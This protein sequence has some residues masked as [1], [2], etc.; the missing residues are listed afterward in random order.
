MTLPPLSE[1]VPWLAE[2]NAITV[3]VWP[4][5]SLGPALSLAVR[6]LAEN[7]SAVSSAV[8]LLSELAVGGSLTSVIVTLAVPVLH[9]GSGTPSVV[10]LSHI[11]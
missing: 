8:L 7:V 11:V 4:L 1:T 2:P 9:F 3:S 10:P 6:S 5:S